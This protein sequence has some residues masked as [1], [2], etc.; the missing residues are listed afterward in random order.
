MKISNKIL[1]SVLTN[2]EAKRNFRC[3]GWNVHNVGGWCGEEKESYEFNRFIN[4]VQDQL[5]NLGQQ[6]IGC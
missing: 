1:P 5:L 6:V 3:L 2:G 4:P